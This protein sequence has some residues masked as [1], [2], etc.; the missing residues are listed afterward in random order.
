MGRG[1]GPVAVDLVI[2]GIDDDRRTRLLATHEVG[3]AAPFAPDGLEVHRGLL[4]SEFRR[5]EKNRPRVAARE[6]DTAE[7]RAGGF[8]R[9]VPTRPRAFASGLPRTGPGSGPARRAA[10][11]QWAE[12]RAPTRVDGH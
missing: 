8:G 12:G 2:E 3:H 6:V 1:H 11:A 4:I 9:A 5:I 7:A 10:S